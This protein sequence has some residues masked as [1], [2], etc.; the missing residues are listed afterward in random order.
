MLVLGAARQLL[1]KAG[2]PPA[3]PDGERDPGLL[4]VA[5]AAGGWPIDAFVAALAKHRHF[6][7]E[8]DPPRV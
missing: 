1:D 2:I 5:T 6:E 3:L 7:R 8:T 4:V